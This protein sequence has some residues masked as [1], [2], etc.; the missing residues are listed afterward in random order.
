M[1][2]L[3]KYSLCAI[4]L[5]PLPALAD[6]YVGVNLGYFTDGQDAMVATQFG[7]VLAKAGNL[8][9]CLEG[10]VLWTRASEGG[11]NLDLVPVMINYRLRSDLSPDFAVEAGGGV[12]ISFN[13]LSY[14]S[15]DDSD[16]AFAFQFFGGVLYRVSQNV[17]LYGGVRYLNIQKTTLAGI[18]DN[19]GDDASIEVG[20]RFGF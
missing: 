20:V 19:V 12:G 13:Q 6:G 10:E 8:S 9:H 1:N 17:G 3:L 7:G 11:V 14:G 5:I 4:G 2:K 18:S 16:N 15:F